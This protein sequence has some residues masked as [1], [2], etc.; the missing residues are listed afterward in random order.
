MMGTE[1]RSFA[2]LPDD[3]LLEDLVPE[4]NFYR[5]LEAVLDLSFVRKLVAPLNANGGRPSVDPV[6]F[7]KLQLV[8]FFE[9][10]CSERRLMKVVSDRLSLKW[11]LGY[12]LFE[13]LPDHSSLTRIRERFGLEVF[14]RF[15]ERIVEECV[16][17]GLV[18]GEELF[19]DATKVEANASMESRV[20][21]FSA[22]SH[23]GGHLG[24]LLGGE[25]AAESE[26]GD[27]TSEPYASAELE[28]LPAAADRG[29]R[30]K[31]EGRRDWISRGGKPDRTIVRG[32]YRRRSDYELSPTDPDDSLMQHKK[33][34]TRMGYHAH[35]VVDGGKARVIL[36]VLVTPAD[37][38]ENQPMLDLLW[39]TISRWQARVRRVTG[40]AKY[41]TKEIVATVEK[42]AIRAYVSMADFEK[43]SPYYGASRFFYDAERDLYG[44]PQGASLR[45]YT[46]SY[47]ERLTRY[48]ARAETCNACPPEARVHAGRQRAC[49]HAQLR[50]GAP[51]KGPRLPR[52]H[53][54]REGVAQA[55]GA[56]GAHVRGSQRVARDEALPS[57]EALAGE[58]GGYGD[59]RGTEH[60]ATAHVLGQGIEEVGA[61][62]GP[63]A[64]GTDLLGEWPTPPAQPSSEIHTAPRTFFNGL[65]CSPKFGKEFSEEVGTVFILPPSRERGIADTRRRTAPPSMRTPSGVLRCYTLVVRSLALS[66]VS[67]GAV[68]G[69]LGL[70]KTVVGLVAESMGAGRPGRARR[71]IRT[72]LGLGVFGALGI[73]LAYLLVGDL[74]SEHLFHSSLLVGVTGLMAGWI[75]IAV[76][77]EITAEAFRGFHDIRLAT[78]LGGL[79]TAGKSGGLIMRVLL[80]GVLALLWVRSEQASL[81]TVMLV[82]LGSG[83]VSVVLSLWLLHGKLSTLSP[84]EGTEDEEPVGAKE[85]LGDA[86]PFL[87][88]ALTSFVLLSVDVWILGALGS[89]KEVG[90]YGAASRL[91]T[92]VT[93]PLLVVNLVLPPIVSEMYARGETGRLERTLRTFSTLAG[94]PSLLVLLVFMLLGGP[95]LA[96]VYAAD[97]RKD[98]RRGWGRTATVLAPILP[99][100]KRARRRSP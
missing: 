45:L 96:L 65:G 59:R 92:F 46:H 69:S 80:L 71:V 86:I 64:S 34:A 51:R 63:A 38:T 14:R 82:C 22:E 60:K 55:Q 48:R 49:A 31:N 58:R 67:L 73:G 25:R 8:V 17:A 39:R 52:D 4:D 68:V 81:A 3:L 20:P 98:R 97:T 1:V 53:I 33:G 28:A 61:G 85:V 83:S 23:L 74:V 95:I 89:L 44:C 70:P 79:A 77:Q 75:A 90:I 36:N 91:I 15:F 99:R 40:D 57:Q 12:D 27:E 29:L 56:G 78:L 37:V 26:A 9:D 54:L 42:A 6:V 24:G 2:P 94:V 7:F 43:K 50:R 84:S 21:S 47:T 93:M 41:G 35:Y 88:I 30:A 72:V 100:A 19:F 5:H 62:R 16:E 66:I 11:Y 87:A 10:I 76:T 13:P 32:G 18:W